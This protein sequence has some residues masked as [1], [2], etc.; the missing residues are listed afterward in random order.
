[1][2]AAPGLK[3]SHARAGLKADA[4]PTR[5]LPRLLV[6]LDALPYAESSRERSRRTL[7]ARGLASYGSLFFIT[8]VVLLVAAVALF[9]TDAIAASLACAACA[10]GA[11]ATS[12]LAAAGAA[13]YRSCPD[14]SR[15]L[16]IGF[17]W[18]AAVVL[19]TMT[20]GVAFVVRL[21]FPWL[22]GMANV[23]VGAVLVTITGASFGIELFYLSSSFGG[24]ASTGSGP[25]ARSRHEP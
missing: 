17:A 22:P 15:R 19:A 7:I 6:A 4:P 9:W 23:A 20:A 5:G 21:H 11:F 25:R 1:M 8:G 12:K 3:S 18:M 16:L 10:A 14:S 2:H 13:R 24:Q